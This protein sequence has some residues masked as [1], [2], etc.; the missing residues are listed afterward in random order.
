MPATPHGAAPAAKTTQAT[1]T[2]KWT[3]P[4]APASVRRK[5]AISPSAQSIAI[6]ING[7]PNTVANRN[8]SPT[9][10]IVLNAPVGTDQFLFNVYDLPNGTGHL[11][12]TA[13][14]SQLIVDGA[15]NNVTAVIQAVC[16]ATNVVF[17]ND[18][19]L[20]TATYTVPTTQA[21]TLASI[22]VV[23]QTTG[24]LVVGPEDADGNVIIAQTTGQVTEQITGSATVTLVDGAHIQLT[25][26]GG[27]RTTTPSTLTVSAPGC[28]S[29]AVSVLQSPGI[30]MQNTSGYVFAIDW[31]GNYHLE[32]ALQS[33]DAIVGYDVHTKRLI[34]YNSASG[35]VR[36]YSQYLTNP[37]LL[38]TITT[39]S[40]VTWSNYLDSVFVAQHYAG[41]TE[42]YTV[43]GGGSGTQYSSSTTSGSPVA[44]STTPE[45]N[46]PYGFAT[47][48]TTIY[49]FYF[50]P[51]SVI[52]TTATLAYPAV[53]LAAND[54]TQ[55]VY[56]ANTGSPYV[57]EFYLYVDESS[58][59]SNYG[60]TQPGALIATDVDAN[61]LYLLLSDGVL[62]A[63][64]LGGVNLGFWNYTIDGAGGLV[65]VSSSQR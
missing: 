63:S 49:Q 64:T 16:V 11:L 13:T 30:Y 26:V 37:T 52:N 47:N 48:G 55:E 18:D 50:S 45:S 56:V 10:S 17:A 2:I 14:V 31:F 1:F 8:S 15:A 21:S 60:F 58:S 62:Q 32:S 25:P 61:N 65:V 39:G 53:S 4:S 41:G 35:A 3:N 38:Y 54:S 42:Y 23:G 22:V 51:S 7:A 36:A 34:A 44:I 12:G 28:P 33:G 40:V 46:F 59:T 29:T 20:D 19:I 6:L 57:T 43:T 9:Q 27:Q 5:D 24:T